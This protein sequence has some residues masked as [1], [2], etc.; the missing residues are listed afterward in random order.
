MISAGTLFYLSDDYLVEDAVLPPFGLCH[1][2]CTTTPLSLI[3]RFNG[4]DPHRLSSV[5]VP[6]NLQPNPSQPQVHTPDRP[7]GEPPAGHQLVWSMMEALE[8]CICSNIKSVLSMDERSL[9]GFIGNL[10]YQL[11]VFRSSFF[12]IVRLGTCDPGSTLCRR[13]ML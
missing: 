6:Q 12:H 1:Q 10:W 13:D 4:G 3:P 2:R 7:S 5:M 9:F 8:D 11:Q